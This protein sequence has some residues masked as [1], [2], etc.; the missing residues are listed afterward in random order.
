MVTGVS[1]G[2]ARREALVTALTA[3]AMEE[4]REGDPPPVVNTCC[5]LLPPVLLPLVLV[6]LVLLE[7]VLVVAP[8]PVDVPSTRALALITP[9]MA[10]SRAAEVEDG[11][12]VEVEVEM[13]EPE[14]V[15][16]ASLA[17]VVMAVRAEA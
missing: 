7:E 16:V 11:R 1:R 6:L 10:V 14:E 4:A 15:T 8:L 5:E 3:V 12:E 17:A 9:E 13:V 2:E